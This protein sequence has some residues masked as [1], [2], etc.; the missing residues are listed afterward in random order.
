MSGTKTAENTGNSG[1]SEKGKIDQMAASTE[2]WRIQPDR[3]C[4][5]AQKIFLHFPPSI[6][7]EGEK[8]AI[9]FLNKRR[10]ELI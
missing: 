6:R 9:M 1:F 5:V 2:K 7:V 8:Y 4:P 10:L 3:I